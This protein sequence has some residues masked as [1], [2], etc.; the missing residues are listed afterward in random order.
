MDKDTFDT[1]ETFLNGSDENNPLDNRS[2]ETVKDKDYDDYRNEVAQLLKNS[3]NLR[4][5]N[6]E[7]TKLKANIENN[8]NFMKT[9]VGRNTDFERVKNTQENG[10]EI[11]VPELDDDLDDIAL[12]VK[13]ENKRLKMSQM[14]DNYNNEEE[15]ENYDKVQVVFH[16]TRNKIPKRN[17]SQNTDEHKNND[18][19][20]IK[21]GNVKRAV[22]KRKIENEKSDFDDLK[23]IADERRRKS[24]SALRERK[25]NPH[26]DEFEKRKR[27]YKNR[28]DLDEFFTNP[29]KNQEHSTNATSKNAKI[30][31][32]IL[33]L[34]GIVVLV[35]VVLFVRNLF[36]S[37]KLEEAN[38]KVSEF[39][40]LKNDNEELKLDIVALEEQIN[41]SVLKDD[42]NS[43]TN[44][45]ESQNSS[46]D[47]DT[48][49][50]VSGDTLG[51]ISNKFYGNFSSYKRIL[52][53]NG[54]TEETSLQ[55][56]QVL[57]I[58]KN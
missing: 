54:L 12:A 23:D 3:D 20:E 55:I 19:R 9:R 8:D 56:G 25:E 15:E 28:A 27:T 2:N 10:S 26:S 42:E 52:E 30:E 45:G 17:F 35:F 21:E 43:G 11:F 29:R 47:Y 50:V 38:Q 58:P 31:K 24:Q 4:R 39:E 40:Q 18:K 13:K 53:A 14:E 33:A 6:I 51:G 7:G 57:K 48:Y 34:C 5:N 44:N 36:V 32:E 46:D 37:A 41:N 49:T 16:K 22:I 1:D